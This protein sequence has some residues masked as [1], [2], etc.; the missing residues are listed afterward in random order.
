MKKQFLN[1]IVLT[2]LLTPCFTHTAYVSKSAQEARKKAEAEAAK[3]AADEATAVRNSRATITNIEK[4]VLE[5]QTQLQTLS[6]ALK[7]AKVIR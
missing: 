7:N 2:A 1:L 5:I 6:D 4:K 3:E